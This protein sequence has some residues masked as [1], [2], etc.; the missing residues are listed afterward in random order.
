V[1]SSTSL[2]DL[3]AL[4]GDQLKINDKSA[5]LLDSTAGTG[6]ADTVNKMLDVLNSDFNS[7]GVSVST[8]SELKAD[9]AG[10][11]VLV[12][13]TSSIS[14]VVKDGN[15]LDQTLNITGT[16]SMKE[17]VDKIN[18]SAGGIV[19][20]SLSDAGKLVLTSQNSESITIN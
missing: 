15:G 19:Q 6:N 8:V 14:I 2:A 4:T 16:N 7:V 18:E 17:V 10:S 1:G 3:D 9:S 5:T 11:G 13:G 20:A 12:A